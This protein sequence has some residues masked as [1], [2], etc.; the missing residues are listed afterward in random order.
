MPTGTN[1]TY[2]SAA[3]GPGHRPIPTANG[4]YRKAHAP[5]Q[6][7]KSSIDWDEIRRRN[8]ERQSAE[9]GTV[10]P[11]ETAPVTRCRWCRKPAVAGLVD[12]LCEECRHDA[13][14]QFQVPVDLPD[15][16]EPE[17]EPETTS[18]VGQDETA[19]SGPPAPEAPPLATDT[20]RLAA[21]AGEL[22]KASRQI[23][24]VFAELGAAFEGLTETP[25]AAAPPGTATPAA[26]WVAA[27]GSPRPRRRSRRTPKQPRSS[28]YDFAEVRR[29]YLDEQLSC[30]QVAKRLGVSTTA[31]QRALKRADIPMRDDRATN[32][33][34]HKLD[35]DQ[36]A[37]IC[38]RYQAGESTVQLAEAFGLNTKT[39]CTVLRRG[40]VQARSSSEAQRLQPRDGVDQAAGLK[41]RIADLGV[42]SREVKAWALE[43]GLITEIRR[44][45]CPTAL[46]DA[47]ESAHRKGGVS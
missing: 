37:E 1:P 40:G 22:A 33:G 8:A 25:V 17:P 47:Y 12:E 5:Q 20:V 24:Q 15:A 46:V 11:E 45:I 3:G 14:T 29:L 42:T 39:V 9:S 35:D 30:P 44:G 28:P 6:A 16:P 34:S 4:G 19:P 31:V 10:V 32:S 2:I 13:E 23:A 41:Q 7:K 43:R 26:A 21:F 18:G 38:R 27:S 36:R